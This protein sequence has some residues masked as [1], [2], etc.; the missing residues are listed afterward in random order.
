MKIRALIL[1]L[2]WNN[3]L[4]MY[5]KSH[6]AG[7]VYW[8]AIVDW[9]DIKHYEWVFQAIRQRRYLN[10][11]FRRLLQNTRHNDYIPYRGF[12]KHRFIIFADNIFQNNIIWQLNK[13]DYFS[14]L[15]SY[16]TKRS[17]FDCCATC[18]WRLFLFQTE[19]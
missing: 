17:T 10:R 7:K 16:P 2:L 13:Y 1:T 18:K 9:P 4:H 11:S 19:K 8:T 6:I 5:P 3:W 15:L 14:I 12:D